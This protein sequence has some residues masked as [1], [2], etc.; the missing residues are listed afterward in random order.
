[1]FNTWSCL[2]WLFF[3]QIQIEDTIDFDETI[4]LER[5]QNL[6]EIHVQ[7]ASNFLKQYQYMHMFFICSHLKI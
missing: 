5:G 7:K 3:F 1:M 2:C 4:H 6:F